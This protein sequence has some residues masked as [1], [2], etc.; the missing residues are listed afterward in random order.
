MENY[1]KKK[2]KNVTF[3]L[4]LKRWRFRRRARTTKIPGCLVGA[5]NGE[6]EMLYN[7]FTERILRVTIHRII[8]GI[9]SNVYFHTGPFVNYHPF[10]PYR[11]YFFRGTR[12]NNTFFTRNAR[13]L[14][15]KK[16]IIFYSFPPPWCTSAPSRVLTD[17]CP[18]T[19]RRQPPNPPAH[20]FTEKRTSKF[21]C[22]P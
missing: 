16:C 10:Q 20:S 2:N 1:E 19:N 18:H 8:P 3:T 12:K 21:T 13:F 17:P 15:G 11:S 14:G 7:S 22:V 6:N 4:R 5:G 9:H